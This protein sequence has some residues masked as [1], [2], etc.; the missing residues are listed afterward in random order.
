MSLEELLIILAF[1][2]QLIELW[3]AY[4][5]YK[6]EKETASNALDR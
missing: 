3:L 2:V 1:I 5:Q 4:Q 6:R